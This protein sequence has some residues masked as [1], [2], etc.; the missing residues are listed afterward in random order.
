M[1]ATRR[2]LSDT[3]PYAPDTVSRHAAPPPTDTV[4]RPSDPRVTCFPKPKKVIPLVPVEEEEDPDYVEDEEDEEMEED[5]ELGEIITPHSFRQ[6][7]RVLLESMAA[8]RKGDEVW[9]HKDASIRQLVE[10]TARLGEAMDTHWDEFTVH[11]WDERDPL[12]ARLWNRPVDFLEHVNELMG[13]VMEDILYILEN[14]K[15]GK[16]ITRGLVHSRK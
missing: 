15:K 7:A 5:L 11:E 14:A 16:R 9:H 10:Q 12:E 3:L 6:K 1:S 2:T 4:A 13:D 8:Q